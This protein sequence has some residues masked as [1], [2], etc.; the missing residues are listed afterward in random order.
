M[1]CSFSFVFRCLQFIWSKI[2]NVVI[3]QMACRMRKA[4]TCRGNCSSD[5]CRNRSPRWVLQ[6]NLF[7][8]LFAA[9]KTLYF[10]SEEELHTYI[11]T[12]I[13]ILYTLKSRRKRW[14]YAGFERGFAVWLSV[15]FLVSYVVYYYGDSYFGLMGGAGVH[16]Y[17]AFGSNVIPTKYSIMDE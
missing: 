6:P 16:S 17:Y 8:L 14:R 10:F 11:H 2:Y 7:F 1:P 12:Y 13:I 3:R 5:R 4:C 15:S 9:C